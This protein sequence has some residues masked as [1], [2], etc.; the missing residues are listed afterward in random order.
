M[1][2]L[3]FDHEHFCMLRENAGKERAE[4]YRKQCQWVKYRERDFSKLEKQLSIKPKVESEPQEEAAEG[5][6]IEEEKTTNL[7]D[8]MTLDQKLDLIESKTGKRPTGRRANDEERLDKKIES[9][10]L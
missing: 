5:M 7:D 10:S 1:P 2:Q 8:E 3:D 4:E 9:L 6:S